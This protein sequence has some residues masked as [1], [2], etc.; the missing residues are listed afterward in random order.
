MDT[1]RPRSRGTAGPLLIVLLLVGALVYGFGVDQ[2][3]WSLPWSASASQQQPFVVAPSPPRPGAGPIDVEA[4]ARDVVP[5]LVNIDVTVEP[6]GSAGAGSGIVLTDTGQVVTSHHVIKGASKISVTDVGTGLIYDATTVGYDSTHDIAL[7]QM[8]AAQGLPTARLGTSAGV[9]L[10]DQLAAI[11]NAGGVGGIPTPVAGPA[12]DLDTTIVARNDAD[13]SRK[14]LSGLIEVQA[15]VAA[16][17][18]GGSLVNR[19]G[20]VVG[21]VTAASSSETP[22]GAQ[23]AD[24]PAPPPRRGFA[25]P[26]DQV[27]TIVDDIRA[28]RASDTV[29][30][31]PTAVLGLLVS[32]SRRGQPEGARVDAALYGTPADDAG[33]AEGDLI[34]A[35]DGKPIDS[36]KT[37][38]AI[39]SGHSPGDVIE[40]TWTTKDGVAKVVKIALEEG[41]AN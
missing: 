32:D 33:M 8:A 18:S 26:I 5:A 35:L 41:P 34:T 2:G 20:E 29:H 15:D 7:I 19:V 21:V 9:E 10:G 39:I 22:E 27:K 24:T 14:F 3:Q 31:G 30:I 17:Q 36:A 25:V 28:G 23:A 1:D 13:F 16:G 12:V 37:M 11:G 4:V 38:R 40:F 6:L